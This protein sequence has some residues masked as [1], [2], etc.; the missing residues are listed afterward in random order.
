MLRATTT[1]LA[2]VNCI[3]SGLTLIA[4]VI[5]RDQSVSPAMIGL[6][7]G[8]GAVGGLAGAPLV[9]P[10]HRLRPGALLI[11]VCG[12]LVPLDALLALPYGPWW[13]AGVLFIAMLGIPSIRVLVDVLILRQA[14]PAERGRVVGAVMTLITV[15]MPAGLAA[16]G[17]LLEYLPAQSAV[18]VLAGLLAIGVVPCAFRRKLWAARWPE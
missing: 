6:A 7:L 10:L 17:L 8:G 16:S 12:L 15:G 13:M 5:L 4:V 2:T 18:L 9:R 1:L 3:C 11:A 14:P